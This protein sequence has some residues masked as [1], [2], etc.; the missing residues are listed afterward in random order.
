VIDDRVLPLLLEVADPSHRFA[1]LGH[2]RL[3]LLPKR[4]ALEL[5]PLHSFQEVLVLDQQLLT[6]PRNIFI[7]RVDPVYR[8]LQLGNQ[9]IGLLKRSHEL[10]HLFLLVRERLLPLLLL[11]AQRGINHLQSEAIRV[12]PFN[13]FGQLTDLQLLLTNDLLGL[14]GLFQLHLLLLLDPF[15][16]FLTE[17][18]PQLFVLFL[19]ALDAGLAQLADLLSV[20]Q[21]APEALRLSLDCPRLA[22]I[23]LKPALLRLKRIISSSTRCPLDLELVH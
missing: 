3:I 12:Q 16:E 20:L 8:L 9:L 15:L 6:L 11:G 22:L 5:Q 13:L 2:L 23:L 19:E 14:K 1:G 7:L 21:L 4:F 10:L 17:V 18:S